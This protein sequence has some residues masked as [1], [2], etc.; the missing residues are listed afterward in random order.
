MH[1]IMAKVCHRSSLSKWAPVWVSSC[2]CYNE[3]DEETIGYTKPFI[4][5]DL[6]EKMAQRTVDKESKIWQTMLAILQVV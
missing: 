5:N 1:L 4:A 6:G 3:K 2:K